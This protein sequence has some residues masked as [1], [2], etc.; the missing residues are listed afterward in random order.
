[1]SNHMLVYCGRNKLFFTA[2]LIFAF[3]LKTLAQQSI[4]ATGKVTD[5]SKSLEGVSVLIKGKTGGT[6][7]K[8]DGSFSINANFQGNEMTLA[9]KGKVVGDQIKLSVD[10]PGGGQTIEY[11]LKRAQ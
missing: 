11:T 3:S 8:A 5:G 9:Y 1:M 4:V 6:Y 10:F 7:T 2:L